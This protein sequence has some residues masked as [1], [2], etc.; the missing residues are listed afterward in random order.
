MLYLTLKLLSN[1]KTFLNGLILIKI[2]VKTILTNKT[3]V[4]YNYV[5]IKLKSHKNLY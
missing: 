1:T 5:E 3:K 4:D 2:K